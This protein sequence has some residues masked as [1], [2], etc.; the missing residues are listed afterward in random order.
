MNT[1]K[2]P[3]GRAQNRFLLWKIESHQRGRPKLI[4]MFRQKR[5]RN[6]Q[7]SPANPLRLD[8][9]VVLVILCM[10]IPLN[11]IF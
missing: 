1:P 2:A 6:K 8:E 7:V 11:Y 10:Q 9:I 4:F 5:I 3:G